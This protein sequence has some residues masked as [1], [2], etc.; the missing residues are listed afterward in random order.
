MIVNV[1]ENP[2]IAKMAEALV[3]GNQRATAIHNA[4]IAEEIRLI[5]KKA[6]KAARAV[7]L[8]DLQ[9]RSLEA[10]T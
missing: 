10:R 3:S 5:G 2:T 4:N 9:R 1:S 8:R 6:R 7:R